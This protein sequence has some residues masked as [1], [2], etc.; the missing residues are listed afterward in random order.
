MNLQIKERL[1]LTLEKFTV[2]QNAAAKEM[3]YSGSVLSAY[4]SGT[5][6]GDISK[7]EN[8]VIKWC[9]RIEQAHA[10]KRVP[11]VET[12]DLK[13]IVNAIAIAH[14]EKDIALIVA[15]AGS[16]KSTAAKYYCDQNPRTTI[17]IQVVSGMNKKIMVQEI[18]KQ[19]S[20]DTS[21]IQFQTLVQ[22]TADALRERNT[23]VILDE[24]D[25]LKSDALE[26]VRRVVYDLGESGLVLIG[27]PR[28][29]GMIQNLKNDH[30]QLESRIGV[31]LPLNGLGKKD[32]T[33]LAKT[34]WADVSKEVIDAIYDV[35]KTDIRQFCK[36]IERCQNLMLLNKVKEPDLDLVEMASSKVI[37]RNFR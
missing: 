20:L 5:Y 16:G 7:I 3:G 15:D 18:A 25:Y 19:L 34:V 33:T 14:T 32:A 12:D 21:K 4:R 9:A 28:L 10:R 23:V 29:K 35:S 24:A 27:L 17:L 36:I 1:E 8:A 26:F 31:Y 13:K 2:S 11:L 30:R 6:A 37:R 22:N